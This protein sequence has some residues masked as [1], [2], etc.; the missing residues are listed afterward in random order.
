MNFLSIGK[1]AGIV[2]L[3]IGLAGCVDMT[4]DILVTSNTAASATVTTVM[5]KDI[6]PM[7]KA[8][9]AGDDAEP[10]CKE[11]GSTLTENADG[12]ATC[13]MVSEGAFADLKFD[14][15]DSSSKP[16]FTAN[17]DGTVRVAV[18][19]KGLI[20]DL[21]AEQDEQTKAMIQQM[22][23]GHFLMLRFGGSEVIET[24]M[25]DVG[26]GYAEKKMSFLD[27]INGTIELPEELYAVVRP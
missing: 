19:T 22:F 23:Q 5:S 24:N 12:S 15:D 1:I 16:T 25:D 20:G 3:T 2:A 21:G 18:E 27:L 4:Q 8:G 17:P 7:I 10:F 11:E 6:Y 9:A 13:V 26:D 14:E